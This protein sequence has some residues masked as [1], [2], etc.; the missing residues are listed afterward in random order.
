M[1]A[2]DVNELVDEFT[3]VA[4]AIA[5]RWGAAIPGW[6]MTSPPTPR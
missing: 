2:P 3:P 6:L 5:A 4:L 1:T